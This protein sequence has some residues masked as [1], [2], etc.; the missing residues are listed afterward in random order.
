VFE[1]AAP[2]D[3]LEFFNDD[4]HRMTWCERA[5]ATRRGRCG[6]ASDCARRPTQDNYDGIHLPLTRRR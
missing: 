1:G 4:A 6:T 3:L 5:G 2:Q